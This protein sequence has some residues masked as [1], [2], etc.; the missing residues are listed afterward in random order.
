MAEVLDTPA[1]EARQG[2]TPPQG[3]QSRKS[4]N[5][6]LD[7]ISHKELDA[8][9]VNF[10]SQDNEY[11][12]DTGLIGT[13]VCYSHWLA[14]VIKGFSLNIE[15]WA[16]LEK[17]FQAG[18]QA[19]P[20][21]SCVW[22][23]QPKGY[24]ADNPAADSTLAIKMFL[25]N[26]KN[27]RWLLT[28]NIHEESQYPLDDPI[29]C[30]QT[31]CSQGQHTIWKLKCQTEETPMLGFLLQISVTL[32]RMDLTTA[33]KQHPLWKEMGE[34]KFRPSTSWLPLCKRIST[35]TMRGGPKDESAYCQQILFLP[36]RWEKG[37]T[38]IG[39]K[40]VLLIF[41]QLCGYWRGQKRNGLSIG[42]LSQWR[43][44]NDG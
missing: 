15:F 5:F 16:C 10:H 32:H 21:L 23:R 43:T 3:Q 1:M 6:S 9:I 25:F 22:C 4:P 17:I 7:V 19:D 41:T 36:L 28:G 40:N 30:L 14:V 39:G 42:P 20:S 24:P 8:I 44:N 12:Y 37:L 11:C 13:A 38:P 2:S 31:W 34:F 26:G 33:L 27:Q 35:Y 18:K 29:A